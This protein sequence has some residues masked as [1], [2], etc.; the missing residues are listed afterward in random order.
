MPTALRTLQPI[1]ITANANHTGVTR[2]GGFSIRASAA[3]FVR[4][5][6]GSSTGQVLYVLDLALNESAGTSFTGHID[7]PSGVYVQVVSGTI[8]GVLYDME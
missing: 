4:L 1:D 7:V 6:H 3:A 5:R 8:E 2:F